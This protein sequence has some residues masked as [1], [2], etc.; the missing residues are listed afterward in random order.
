MYLSN[1]ENLITKEDIVKEVLSVTKNI[2][3]NLTKKINS[4]VKGSRIEV[5]IDKDD[6]FGYGKNTP[7]CFTM[8]G[9]N[10]PNDL[11]NGIADELINDV[12]G[13]PSVFKLII[14]P[15]WIFY[16]WWIYKRKK[17]YNA[18]FIFN[19]DKTLTLKNV[20]YIPIFL[21]NEIVRMMNEN[22]LIAIFLHEVGHHSQYITRMFEKMLPIDASG[23]VNVFTFITSFFIIPFDA[24][25]SDDNG[26]FDDF[27]NRFILIYAPI[28]AC[29]F[30]ISWACNKVFY[31]NV[32]Y[33]SDECAMR[34][35][36]GPYLYSAFKKISERYRRKENI[37]DTFKNICF[38]FLGF[39]TGI[40]AMH[41][42]PSDEDRNER[43]LQYEKEHG[44]V[45]EDKNGNISFKIKVAKQFINVFDN[46]V[47]LIK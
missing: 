24:M 1:I 42:H 29:F 2:D 5:Y 44:N 36:Y 16:I 13:V 37:F 45:T 40:Y 7:N 30:I 41:T 33:V 31:K 14:A 11:A 3:K 18:K 34:C 26:N 47:N 25:N 10:D 12:G 21:T 43:I 20:P 6:S 22:E 9:F 32:E 19:E 23:G 35:G 46:F 15:I 39:F 4:I 17:I 27:K 28:L 8:L 38:K